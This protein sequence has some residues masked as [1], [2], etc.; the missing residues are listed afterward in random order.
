L[1][2]A[3]Q[4]QPIGA[5]PVAA[6]A[7]GISH[8]ADDTNRVALGAY[9]VVEPESG[10]DVTLIATGSEVAIVMQA[11][12]LLAADNVVRRW[13]PRRVSNCSAGN[14]ANTGMKFWT[15]PAD[16]RRGRGRR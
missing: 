1:R 10:R 3:R 2:L 13:S 14:P 5:V 9:V 7:A 8:A 11:A 4:G 6:G 16:R 15:P 12:K